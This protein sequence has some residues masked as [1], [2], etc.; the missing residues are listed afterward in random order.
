MIINVRRSTRAM[1]PEQIRSIV[2]SALRD[3][4]NFPWLAFAFVLVAFGAAAFFGAYLAEKAKNTATREDIEEITAKVES[5]RHTYSERIESLKG[6]I[7][8]R[9]AALAERLKAHQEAY[10]LWLK[11]FQ[12]V[13]NREDI[14]SVV[15]E[16]QDWW[17][18]HC[19][20]LTPEA[21]DAFRGAISAAFVHRDFLGDP[22]LVKENWAK[23]EDAGPAIVKGAELP[24]IG[25]A[26]FA[27]QI[28]KVNANDAKSA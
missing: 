10:A 26:Q 19:L 12:N 7:Q 2:D 17:A 14:G 3:P 8:L 25:E 15:M 22:R 28:T 21:R 4:I 27:M 18:T 16:S 13:H 20:Y 6:L 9:G 23:L 1:T 24:D 11:L 5:V